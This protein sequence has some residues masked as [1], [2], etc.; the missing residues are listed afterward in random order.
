MSQTKGTGNEKERIQRKQQHH[1]YGFA[2]TA[3][4]MNK[5]TSDTMQK[6]ASQECLHESG[7]SCNPDRTHSVSVLLLYVR[8]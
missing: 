7:L 2:T 1:E 5:C 3:A 4:A 8:P 6:F